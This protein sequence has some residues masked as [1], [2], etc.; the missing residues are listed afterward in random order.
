M[1][2]TDTTTYTIHDKDERSSIQ[3]KSIKRIENWYEG[4]IE[5]LQLSED[6]NSLFDEVEEQIKNRHFS[7]VSQIESQI[8]SH[9][10]MV[11]ETKHRINEIQMGKKKSLYFKIEECA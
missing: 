8:L 3:I 1:P 9:A 4:K 2:F 5:N 11:K 7:M 6:L 10:L